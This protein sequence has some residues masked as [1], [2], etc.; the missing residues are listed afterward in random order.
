MA[1]F[2]AILKSVLEFLGLAK[3]FYK[4]FK[5]TPIQKDNEIDAE[6]EAE[7]AKAKKEGRPS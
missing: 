5:K 2:L 1:Q 3:F 7:K 6:I 4:E